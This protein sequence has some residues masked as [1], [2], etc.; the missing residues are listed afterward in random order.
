[1]R[2]NAISSLGCRN[3]NLG[4][5]TTGVLTPGRESLTSAARGGNPERLEAAGG[6][7]GAV[8]DVAASRGGRTVGVGEEIDDGG[9]DDG[10]AGQEGD[11]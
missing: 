9:V 4:R 5:K 8:V 1:M 10:A 11:E 6:C 2:D 3:G 7:A